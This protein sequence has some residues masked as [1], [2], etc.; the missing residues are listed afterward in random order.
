MLNG[1][2]VSESLAYINGAGVDGTSERTLSR[3]LHWPVEAGRL[4]A[5]GKASG[6]RYFAT[7]DSEPEKTATTPPDP[8][9]PHCNAGRNALC[10]Y[11]ATSRT[12][13]SQLMSDDTRRMFDAVHRDGR[14]SADGGTMPRIR[15]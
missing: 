15:M 6:R 3:R 13:Q 5:V 12:T 7:S 11:P 2:G 10:Q 4:R 1:T 9:L 14:G 8:E